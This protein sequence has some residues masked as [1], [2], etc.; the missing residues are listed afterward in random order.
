MLFI[1]FSTGL[2]SETPVNYNT[3][4]QYPFSL[5]IEIQFVNPAAVFDTSYGGKF[6]TIDVAALGRFPLPAL[7]VIQPLAK[8]GF[9]T[10]KAEDGSLQTRLDHTQYYLSCGLG[11][12]HKFS[13]S[14]E[15]GI[16]IDLGLGYSVFQNVKLD[17]GAYSTLNFQTSLGG[18][19]VFSPSYNFSMNIHPFVG[20]KR[21]LQELRTFD[22]FTLGVG[23]TL[24]YRFGSDPDRRSTEYSSVQLV[25]SRIDAA[26]AAMQSYYTRNPVGSVT[27]KNIDKH[28][29]TDIR[30]TFF[31]PGYMNIGTLVTEIDQ[32]EADG[33][34]QIPIIASF[35][36]NIFKFEGVKPLTGELKVTYNLRSRNAEQSI[37]VN[38]DLYDK[39]SLIWDD[40]RKVAAFI[41]SGDSALANYL[42]FLRR[43]TQDTV[44]PG[45][46]EAVQRAMQIYYG[47]TE[48]GTFYQLDPHLSYKD[49]KGDTHLVDSVSLPRE[50]LTKLAGDCDDLMVLFNALLESA[51]I[52]TAF[53]TAPGHIYSAFST[54]IAARDY[55][56]IHPEKA[57]TLPING[58]LWV[59]LEITLIGERSF[60]EAWRLGAEEFHRFSGDGDRLKLYFT[61]NS[62]LVYRPVGFEDSDLGLQYGEPSKITQDF[63]SALDA[64]VER[65]IEHFED[66]AESENSSGSWNRMGIVNAT[67]GEDVRAEKAFRRS[68]SL[69]RNYMPAKTNL[70]RIY[71]VR[72]KYKDALAI[73][74]DVEEYLQAAEQTG[75]GLYS[76][77]LLDISKTYYKMNAFDEA[78]GYYRMLEST[79]AE[80][81]G[82]H[83]YLANQTGFW[84]ADVSEILDSSGADQ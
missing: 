72:E 57:M 2:S 54:G 33:E 4:Y 61:R 73:Y 60:D 48:I 49:F 75:L 74:Q 40:D 36:E 47:L 82:R 66:I 71:Y 51:G 35:D 50:T 41:T 56:L 7:P 8:I 55:R 53:I 15:A 70:G 44:N 34:V 46:S 84:S 37:P 32:L 31:Q 43:I 80:L 24:N 64:A 25:N 81:A 9:Y 18:R 79:N 59:P 14:F 27:L 69:D 3:V 67:F 29:I 13:K 5:G 28:S 42:S 45:Y 12:M 78:E 11:Y 52:E 63:L 17:E 62:Q 1:L 58:V 16:E 83:S 10:A 76:R 30:V 38:Y 6:T 23:I 65:V 19:V 20:Y 39:N 26:F 68:L 22:G 77:L 21:S